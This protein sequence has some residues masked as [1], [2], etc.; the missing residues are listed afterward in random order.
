[1]SL[2]GILN[3]L[4]SVDCINLEERK[5]RKKHVETELKPHGVSVDFFHPRKH[6]NGGMHGCFESHIKMINKALDNNQDNACIF[7]DDIIA[8]LQELGNKRGLFDIIRFLRASPDGR[9]SKYA[10]K[11]WSIFYLG[12]IPNFLGSR[13]HRVD[14]LPSGNIYKVNA[15]CLHAYIISKKG[16]K[17]MKNWKFDGLAID[18]IT[19]DFDDTYAYLPSLFNQGA[20]DSDIDKFSP[21]VTQIRTE[22]M[23]AGNWYSTTI[24][25]PIYY[26]VTVIVVVLVILWLYL[27]FKSPG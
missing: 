11:G 14:D 24:N 12:C 26:V 23:T 1:M 10:P 19:L 16:M 25:L 7:E 13:I 21:V 15:V 8:N 20:F 3:R 6:P 17:R 22:A 27:K 18:Q 9:P 4:G 2:R 5:D